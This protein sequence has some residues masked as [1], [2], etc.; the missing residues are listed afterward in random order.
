V[1][2]GERV[3]S[4]NGV[5]AST[6]IANDDYSGL[7]ANAAGDRLTLV[8]RDAGGG[9]RT[10]VLTATVFDLTPVQGAGVIT[11]QLGRKLGYVMVKDMIAQ[12]ASPLDAAFADF[13]AQG[14]QEVVLDLRYNGGGLVSMAA[15][16]ASYAAG[17]RAVGQAF[18]RLLYNDRKQSRNQ[19]YLFGNP[20]SWAGVSRVYVLA[21][22][23]T[24]SASEQVINGLRV[25]T[26]VQLIAIGD[27]TCGKP[28]GFLPQGDYCG[29]TYSVVNF[30]SVNARNEGRYF[31]GLAAT[32]A[33]AEDFSRPI[34]D[35]ADPLLTVAGYHADNGACPAG[36]AVRDMPQSRTRGKT[37]RAYDGADGG[38]RTGMSAH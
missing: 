17:S 10:V 35:L 33:V 28:V 11:S 3:M 20:A 31:N 30:E 5:S 21:G 18:A 6:V 23:R 16:L 22:E 29:T 12:A 36:T 7:T 25:T 9:D 13:R 38:E 34:G 26:G 14:V 32:C 37:R 8:V 1:Q 19:D 2:R 15:T 27:T 4:I 24:C